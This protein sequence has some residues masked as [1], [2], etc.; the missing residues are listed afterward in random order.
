MPP[1]SLITRGTPAYRVCMIKMITLRR[2]RPAACMGESRNSQKALV[3]SL[4]RKRYVGRPRSGWNGTI[5][6]CVKRNVF[7]G[8]ELDSCGSGYSPV[9]AS[10]EESNELLSSIKRSEIS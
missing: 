3:G 2:T 6:I 7:S 10:Y 5:K 1:L 4:E 9:A 8:C